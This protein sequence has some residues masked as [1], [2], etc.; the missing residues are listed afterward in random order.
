MTISTWEANEP[1]EVRKITNE[2]NNPKTTRK[3]R[4]LTLLCK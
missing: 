4:Q 2:V 3:L 1:R